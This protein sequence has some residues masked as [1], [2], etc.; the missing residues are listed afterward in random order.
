MRG[1][2]WQIHQVQLLTLYGPILFK[3]W[4]KTEK[5]GLQLIHRKIHRNQPKELE[6]KSTRSNFV[7]EKDLQSQNFQDFMKKMQV[8]NPSDTISTVWH[9]QLITVY[10]QY[11]FSLEIFQSKHHYDSFSWCFEQ[12]S[13]RSLSTQFF[14]FSI[15]FFFQKT[16]REIKGKIN[17]KKT[18]EI[19]SLPKPFKTT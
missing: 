14:Y 16:Q 3:T 8:I 10:F 5:N 9:Q 13:T 18:T 15:F 12:I 19:K 11:S 17:I 4:T 1:S 2:K 6:F 7:L